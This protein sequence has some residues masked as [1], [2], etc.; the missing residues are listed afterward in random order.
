MTTATSVPTIVTSRAKALRI[1]AAVG[2]AVLF[3]LAF[4]K[5]YAKAV[6]PSRTGDLTRTAILRWKPQIEDL[7]RGVNIYDVH[8]Y[9]NPPIMALLLR[10]IVAGSPATTFAVWFA[11]KVLLA[12]V[13]VAVAVRLVGDGRRLPDGLVIAAI[14]LSLH[15]IVGD[16]THGN[17]NIAIAAMVFGALALFRRRFDF[18]AG[19]LLALAIACKVTP[20]L[21]VPYFVWKRAWKTVAGC[22]AGLALWVA[23]VPAVVLGP[24]E[25]RTLTES[26][27][28][29]MVKP[30]VVDGKVT[31]EH[32][33]QSIPGVV[34]RLLTSEPSFVTY[35]ED[36][37]GPPEAAEFHTVVDIGTG[38]AKRLTKAVTLGF[39]LLILVTC[40]L[41]THGP[42]GVRG[43][44]RFA[45]E[46]SLILLG[47]L[48]L[49]ERTWKHHSVTLILP[50]LTLLVAAWDRRST[51]LAAAVVAAAGLMLGQSAL[52]EAG[53]N[54]ALVYGVY[55]AAYGLLTAG[56]V[57][58]LL[59]RTEPLPS[60]VVP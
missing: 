57:A 41:R 14:A 44:V 48:L 33:N 29:T 51:M 54:L 37:N 59:G 15:P 12:G 50:M 13:L 43:G 10:P 38:N 60:R 53:Q 18:S 6:T 36:G 58:V 56:I 27:F 26:W 34:F 32:P 19:L 30:F 2:V 20:A 45:A 28:R 4:A 23:V 22:V 49:S 25:T 52:P 3:G 16:L 31:S 24:A 11:F 1:A 17:V 35:G 39:G 8:N 7:A 42:A 5:S 40:R 9:P 55:T 46:C 47:M 21:F